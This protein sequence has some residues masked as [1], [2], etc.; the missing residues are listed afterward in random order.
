VH[1]FTSVPANP[2]TL[3]LHKPF[4]AIG[5]QA[6]CALAL[7]LWASAAR[8]GAPEVAPPPLKAGKRDLVR[9]VADLFRFAGYQHVLVRRY[10]Q[11]TIRDVAR[12]VHTPHGLTETASLDWLQRVGADRG[13]SLDCAD[14]SARADVLAAAGRRRSAELFTLS[15]DIWRWK[16]EMVDGF[17]GSAGDRGRDPRRGPQGRGG[18]G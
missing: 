11:E 2:A 4:T 3:L 10:I 17:A 16:Q 15:R 14:L 5:L 13:V 9:N 12:R 8:F 1:G 18:A 6:V 7:L